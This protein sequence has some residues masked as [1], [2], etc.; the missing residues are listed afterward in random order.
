MEFNKQA[1][2]INNNT[3]PWYIWFSLVAFVIL[4][5][6]TARRIKVMKGGYWDNFDLWLR[7]C[8]MSFK[9]W[10]L[11]LFVPLAVLASLANYLL[12]DVPEESLVPEIVMLMILLVIYFLNVYSTYKLVLWRNKNIPHLLTGPFASKKNKV[13]KDDIENEKENLDTSVEDE[14]QIIDDNEENIK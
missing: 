8:G 13:E 9:L 2:V 7:A 12:R 5:G 14:P 11:H 3:K 6:D 10:V 4:W 1:N